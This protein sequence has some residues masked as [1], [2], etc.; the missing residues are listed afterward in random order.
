[1][2]Y[3]TITDG[4]VS[5][6]WS[7]RAASR[8]VKSPSFGIGASGISQYTIGFMKTRTLPAVNQNPEDIIFDMADRE[9]ICN[10]LTIFPHSATA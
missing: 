5:I 6:I 2:P 10:V 4:L 3:Q 1:M 9:L 7:V 8:S